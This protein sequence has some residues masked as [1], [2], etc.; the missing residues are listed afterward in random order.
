[1]KKLFC[2]F[3]IVLCACSW[4]SPNSSFYM[5]NSEGLLPISDKKVNIAVAKVKVPDLLDRAQI[6]VYEAGNDQVQ[7]M[8]FNRW[9]EVLPD[10]IQATVVN[11]L[12]AYYYRHGG[13][14]AMHREKY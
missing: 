13:I 5:M 2:L 11:D 8:E 14:L 1:M 7:I 12:I 9:G 4:R 6:V 3:V 10:V